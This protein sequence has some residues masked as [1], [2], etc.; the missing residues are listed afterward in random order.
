MVYDALRRY[1]IGHAFRA[2][3]QATNGSDRLLD[4]ARPACAPGQG[5]S[6]RRWSAVLAR[7]GD[8]HRCHAG[9]GQGLRDRRAARSTRCTR[10]RSAGDAVAHAAGGARQ[11]AGEHSWLPGP[12]APRRMSKACRRS[13]WRRGPGFAIDDEENEIPACAVS[14]RR[15]S[16]RMAG[17]WPQ[18]ACSRPASRMSHDV[19]ASMGPPDP[20]L[21]GVCASSP[22]RPS[23][24]ADTPSRERQKSA[25]ERN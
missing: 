15:S 9:S 10:R 19:I 8:A 12:S 18:S 20:G 13:N 1:S 2:Y 7:G 22:I 23:A 3:I 5:Q 24:S 14:P 25:G 21:H 6:A 16:T 17:R 11:S 4:A